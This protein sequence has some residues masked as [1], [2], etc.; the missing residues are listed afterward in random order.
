MEVERLIV[1]R[2]VPFELNIQVGESALPTK[3]EHVTDFKKRNEEAL[4]RNRPE[5]FPPR[6]K[7]LY[8]CFSKENAYEW[9]RIKYSNRNTPYKLLTLEVCGELF[10]LKACCY[11]RIH[12]TDSQ[13]I[14]NKACV[15]YWNSLV[16]DNRMLTIGNEYEGLFVGENKIIDIEFKN[17]IN[18]ESF[19][20]E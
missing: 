18:G 13:D 9:A 17:Y 8:I 5:T 15:D 19:D 6:D 16:Q 12:E 11:N 4:E 1:Y 2:I 3:W 7:C 10:W 14:L 20:V